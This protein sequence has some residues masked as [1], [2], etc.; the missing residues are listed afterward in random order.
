MNTEFSAPPPEEGEGKAAPDH[1]PINRLKRSP[2][3][4]RLAI[5]AKCAECMGC[6]PEAF[7]PGFRTDIRSCTSP[8]CPLYLVRPYQSRDPSEDSE[9]IDER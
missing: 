5:N 4:L 3:S 9:V 2:H 1:N 7:A 6:T 8:D